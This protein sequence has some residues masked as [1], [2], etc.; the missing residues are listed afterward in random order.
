MQPR[1]KD[2]KIIIGQNVSTYNNL[3]ICCTDK[4]TIE[5]DTLIGERVMIIDH[6]AHGINACD[7]CT[8][9][10]K[11]KVIHNVWIGSRVTILSGTVTG[12]NTIVGAGLVAN[13][14]FPGNVIISGNPE[15]IIK[16]IEY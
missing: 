11:I 6:D 15:K 7:R 8:S 10:G 3:F 5:K 13:G 12:K 2:S 9:I 14:I 4:I 1:Y 16:N